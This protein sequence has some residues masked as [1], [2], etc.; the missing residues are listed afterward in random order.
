MSRFIE[1]SPLPSDATLV[2]VREIFEPFSVHRLAIVGDK[3]YIQ[4]ND[5]DCY[6]ALTMKYDTNEVTELQNAKITL[7]DA[8]FSWP[9]DNSSEK[10]LQKENE[11]LDK[12]ET[13]T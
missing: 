6:D 10:V 5:N 3:A 9:S 7:L 1:I 13:K 4:F 12:K 8:D 2:R 11:N